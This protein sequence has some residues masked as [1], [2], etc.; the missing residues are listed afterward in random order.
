VIQ[1]LKNQDLVMA[2]YREQSLYRELRHVIPIAVALDGGST[3]TVV[4]L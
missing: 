1:E 2:G 4:E 3:L